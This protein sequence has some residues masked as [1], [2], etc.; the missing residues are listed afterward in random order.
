[1]KLFVP[2]FLVVVGILSAGCAHEKSTI[3]SAPTKP[4][5]TAPRPIVTPDNFLSAKVVAYDAVGRFVV[6]S[7]PVGEMPQIGRTLFLYSAGLKMAKVKVTGPQNDNNIVAD[8]V[9]GEAKVGD[10][11]R[12]Q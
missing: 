1:M 9:S 12:E 8:L 4:A 5:V 10:E 2:V 6:L 11:V 7:F 3:A